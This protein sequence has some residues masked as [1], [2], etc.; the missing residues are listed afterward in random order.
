MSVTINLSD[1]DIDETVRNSGLITI[2][3]VKALIAEIVSSIL[4]ACNYKFV[5]ESV[6][7]SGK[8]II[9]YY[10]CAR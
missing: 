1:P 7:E 8:S 10:V 9:V 4:D 6:S 3:N 2:A 5:Y